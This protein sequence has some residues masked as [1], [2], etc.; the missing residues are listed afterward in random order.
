MAKTKIAVIDDRVDARAL[1][2]SVIDD[3]ITNLEITDKWS[4]LEAS[5]LPKLKDYLNWVSDKKVGILIID[6]RL[7]EVPDDAGKAASYK[8]S[9]L[10]NLLRKQYK[11]MPIYGVTSYPDDGSLQ[12]HFALF[13]EV[14]KR[15]DFTSKAAQYV[16]RFLRTYKN[17]L[18]DNEKELTELSVISK[19]IALGKASRS[20]KKRAE[21]IQ[22]NLEI[23]VTTLAIGSRKEWIDDY[24]KVIADLKKTQSDV[25][26]F[27]KKST[28][29]KK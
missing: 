19:K 6:E 7:G 22:K 12:K 17:F 23:P 15:D 14:V 3:A 28:K 20:E 29:K 27:L 1:V 16:D 21:A 26:K 10:V 9:D 5:P 25:G 18:E 8:G 11:D 24:E 13:D 4:V 2:A